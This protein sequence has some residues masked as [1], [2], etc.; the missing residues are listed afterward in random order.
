MSASTN[1][2][3]IPIKVSETVRVEIRSFLGSKKLSE[4]VRRGPHVHDSRIIGTGVRPAA[5]PLAGKNSTLRTLP[6]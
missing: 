1:T 4:P 2:A 5:P 3:T 6:A